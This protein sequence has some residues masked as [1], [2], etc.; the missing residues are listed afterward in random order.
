MNQTDNQLILSFDM[1][2]T[3]NHIQI[4]KL[5]LPCFEPDTQKKLAV[6]IKYLEFQYTVAY[7]RKN[8]ALPGAVCP[9]R[10]TGSFSGSD[11]I[12]EIF[13]RI[14]SFCTPTERAMF[15]QFSAMKKNMARYEEILNMVQ[16]FSEFSSLSE[17]T[18]SDNSA[19]T[20]NPMDFLK[21]MLTGEQQAMFDLFSAAFSPDSTSQ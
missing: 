3:N 7:F 14:R 2:Y 12:I 17:N 11:D 18:S 16:L 4:L 20:S 10:T 9:D 1:L 13:S 8:P 6:M 5:L 19:N 21:N 15:D